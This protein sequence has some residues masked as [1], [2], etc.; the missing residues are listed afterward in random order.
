M[1]NLNTNIPISVR[2][3]GEVDDDGNVNINDL[4][5][6]DIVDFD[7]SKTIKAGDKF[8]YEK[9][10]EIVKKA[11]RVEKVDEILNNYDEK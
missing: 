2:Y 4:L 1:T 8:T 11:K 10:I 6:V 5:S 3:T 7:T 9:W